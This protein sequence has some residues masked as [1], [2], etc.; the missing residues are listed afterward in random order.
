LNIDATALLQ[1]TAS[2]TSAEVVAEVVKD[3]ALGRKITT[4]DIVKAK[5]AHK[6][7]RA[8]AAPKSKTIKALPVIDPIQALAGKIFDEY[9]GDGRYRLLPKI[10]A[11]FKVAP[12]SV[13]EALGSLG[14]CVISRK[15]NGELEYKVVRDTEA[16]LRVMLAAR[17]LKIAELEARIAELEAEIER[18]TAPAPA[19]ALGELVH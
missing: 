8:P 14:G 17:D 7:K 6:A 13:R 19:P 11:A 3:A 18:Y 2:T 1:L 9:A 5:A 10:A 15:T 4:K 12:T 16:D